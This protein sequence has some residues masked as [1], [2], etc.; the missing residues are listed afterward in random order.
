[1]KNKLFCN[2]AAQPPATKLTHVQ[3]MLLALVGIVV[4]APRARAGDAPQWMHAVVNA[5]VPIHDEK[6]DAVLLYSE[7][8]VNVISADKIKT[9][10]R[11]VYKILRPNGREYGIVFASFRSPGEKINNMHGW[12]IP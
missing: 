10:V 4:A 8:S 1:M 9:T 7:E 6:T 12:C 2:R 3:L 5:P 11:R